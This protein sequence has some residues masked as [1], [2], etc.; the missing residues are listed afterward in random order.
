METTGI[1]NGI[2]KGC[3]GCMTEL[4]GSHYNYRRRYCDECLR[5]KR[6]ATMLNWQRANRD[7][8]AAIVKRYYFNH[9]GKRQEYNNRFRSTHPQYNKDYGIKW[10]KEHPNYNKD[11][12]WEL[13]AKKL[14]SAKTAEN[15]GRL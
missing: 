8:I 13:K 3:L 12:Y 6:A 5:K 15:D 10:R 11:K 14:A 7:K 1:E 2:K 9:P 4:A